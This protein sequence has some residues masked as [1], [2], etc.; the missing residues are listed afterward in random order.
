MYKTI[1]IPIDLA[2]TEVAPEMIEKARKLADPDTRFVL[3]NV[4]QDVPTY[5]AAE[6]PGGYLKRSTE[7][8]ETELKRVAE[9]AGLTADVLVRSGRASLIILEMAE[10]EGADLIIIASHEPGIEDYFLGSTAS[11]VVRH[12]P[13]S[14]LV[15]R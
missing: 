9:A 5:V 7:R 6:I 15:L 13:C 4:V 3:L 8:G 11:R 14:V 2:H 12:A 10:M 1:M